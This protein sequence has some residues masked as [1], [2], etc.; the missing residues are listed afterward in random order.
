MNSFLK[1][2]RHFFFMNFQTSAQTCEDILEGYQQNLQIVFVAI[3][4]LKTRGG[5]KETRKTRFECE[6]KIVS[7]SKKIFC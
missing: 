5:S 2:A 4:L 1:F 7:I 3:E 6:Y